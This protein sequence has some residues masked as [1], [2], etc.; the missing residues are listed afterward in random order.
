LGADIQYWSN[1]SVSGMRNSPTSDNGKV[2]KLAWFVASFIG[3][4]VGVFLGL[5]IR[6]Y[7]WVDGKWENG[8]FWWAAPFGLKV[9]DKSWQYIFLGYLFDIVLALLIGLS[10]SLSQRIV[11]KATIPWRNSL[12]IATI[13]GAIIASIL[14]TTYHI[15]VDFQTKGMTSTL[16]SLVDGFIGINP[17][18]LTL[19]VGFFQYFII[20]KRIMRAKVLLIGMLGIIAGMIIPFVINFIFMMSSFCIGPEC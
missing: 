11:L 12:F 7:F 17:L 14:S 3:V 4:L 9:I 2:S 5:F 15:A 20:R 6:R 8:I 10:L 19:T 1:L 16:F 18:I 13:F